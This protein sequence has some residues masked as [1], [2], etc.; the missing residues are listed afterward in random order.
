M[1][2]RRIPDPT[3]SLGGTD[4]FRTIFLHEFRLLVMKQDSR[5]DWVLHSWYELGMPRTYPE[6][7]HAP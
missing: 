2:F 7:L 1:W 3:S 5:G 6:G 4:G